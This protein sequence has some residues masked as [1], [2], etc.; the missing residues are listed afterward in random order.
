MTLPSSAPG[1]GAD[2]YPRSSMISRPV[3]ALGRL[4]APPPTVF[5][6]YR[7]ADTPGHAGRLKSDLER[8]FGRGHVLMDVY[9]IPA[10]RD[11]VAEIQAAL[12]RCD[13]LLVMIGDQWLRTTQ[14]DAGAE[15][16][17]YVHFEIEYAL[18]RNLPIIP[19]LVE[20][21]AMLGAGALPSDLAPFARLQAHEL[22]DTRWEY[23]VS[24]LVESI[25][26]RVSAQPRPR[27][28]DPPAGHAWM[29]AAVL[30]VMLLV[31]GGLWIALRS[32]P[33]DPAKTALLPP[34]SDSVPNSEGSTQPRWRYDHAKFHSLVDVSFQDTL[35]ST[36][37][38]GLDQVLGFIEADT[39]IKD[40][41][42]AAYILATVKHETANRWS[43]IQEYN[44]GEGTRY[45][46]GGPYYGRGYVQL[47]WDMNY[48]QMSK[49]LGLS[50]DENLE[51]H[52]SRA[53]EPRIAYLITSYGMRHGSF[54]GK[55]LADYLT[56]ARTDYVNAR[57]I[58]NGLDQARRIAG[59]A[60]LF[61][62][63]LRQSR[64]PPGQ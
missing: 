16:P 58:I 56:P 23:D 8:V 2:V 22:S 54:T 43:P 42:W 36:Q 7:R 29:R 38:A 32:P 1:P 57:K 39:A 33:A 13:V 31:G 26:T 10:G 34:G 20:N 60:E 51:A 14:D 47:T 15:Q 12:D 4:F 52:P 59:Y 18:R 24:R 17:D 64:I 41:T 45:A 5:L 49:A 44:L 9:L 46:E 25:R 61:E 30:L 21:A 27:P 63:I 50:A 35:S 53:L 62:S 19:V 40:V 6:S 55:K 37:R 3:K 48:R 28:V 11:F